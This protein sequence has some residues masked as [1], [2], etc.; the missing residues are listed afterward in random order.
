MLYFTILGIIIY[1]YA[2]INCNLIKEKLMLLGYE[3]ND[4]VEA[5]GQFSIRGGII[6]IFSLEYNNPIRME[7]FDDEIDYLRYL[8]LLNDIK[9]NYVL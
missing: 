3:R 4:L 2:N 9:K 1:R 7:L 5:R 6:D 8:Q